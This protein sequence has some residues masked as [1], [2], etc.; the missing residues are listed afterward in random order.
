[1]NRCFLLIVLLVGMLFATSCQE[2]SCESQIGSLTTFTLKLPDQI[3]TK[4]FGDGNSTNETINKLYVQVYSEY[5]DKLIYEPL[6]P[7]SVSSGS[8]S[9][10]VNLIQ[11]QK[12]DIIFWAQK[13]DAYNTSDLRLIPMDKKYHNIE[14]GAAFF[15]YLND[16]IPTGA[17][18][19][20]E[21][22]RPFAQ[23]NLGT[24]PASLKTDVQEDSIKLTK[25]YIKVAN[26]AS[27]FNT[28]L[29]CGEG[30]QVVEF[31]LANVPTEKLYVD[32][33]MYYY[34]S[35]DYLPIAGDKQALVT[36]NASITLD[37]DDNK[38]VSHE[39]VNVPVKENYRT[40][41]IGNLISST[42]DFKVSIDEDFAK[43]N[44]GNLFPDNNINVWDG[45]TLS[46][47]Y[48]EGL[49][50]TFVINDASELA[51]L[52]AVLNDEITTQTPIESI[53]GCTLLVRNNL[54]FGGYAITP[55]RNAY[56]IVFDGGGY[57]ISDLSYSKGVDYST[58]F[59]LASGTFKDIN[60]INIKAN[61]PENN[62]ASALIGYF[63]AGS[64]S[65]VSVRNLE[66]KGYQKLAGI[67]ANLS[68]DASNNKEILVKDCVVENIKI[69]AGIRGEVYQAGGL[70]GYINSSSNAIL[71]F[72]N[73][74]VN[75]S[76]EINDTPIL[77]YPSCYNF[78]SNGF[79]G[80]ISSNE[81]DSKNP[82]IYI[83]DC[84]VVG[85]SA[86]PAL[87]LSPSGCSF[88]GDCV[89]EANP[90]A[91][92]KP[93]K[94]YIDG[95]KY[96]IK[97][98]DQD[99]AASGTIDGYDYVDL[100]LPSGL[101]W[102]TCNVGASS[103]EGYGDYYAWGELETK[104]EYS[105]INSSTHGKSMND[106]SGNI[107]FDVVQSKWGI[108]WRMPKNTELLELIS[109]CI[110]E[111]T[112]V[113]DI[114]GWKVTGSNG[115]SIFLPAAGYKG[116]PFYCGEQGFYWSSTPYNDIEHDGWFSY[117]LWFNHDGKAVGDCMRRDGLTIRPVSDED[118]LDYEENQDYVASGTIDGYDYV[119]LGL[120]S[121]LKWA[122]CNVGAS[123]IYEIGD[124]YAWGELEPGLDYSPK[125][126]NDISGNP[127]YDVATVKWSSNWRMPTESE[128]KELLLCCSYEWVNVGSCYGYKVIG[129][130]G[131]S[132]FFP[133]SPKYGEF[134]YWGSTSISYSGVGVDG[135]VGIGALT[136]LF[137]NFYSP[138]FK[139]SVR[140][141][142]GNK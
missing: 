61:N 17:S 4:A 114:N 25:S 62:R 26:V 97:I 1:M 24:S 107:N 124:L 56:N 46:Q 87:S 126:L 89:T 105:E 65:G 78:Y 69:G 88:F 141:V 34:I 135:A 74:E 27:F 16:F 19:L 14:D 113:K 67:I 71:R 55:I 96:E 137:M 12:Y 38:K 122:T 73:C 45:K 49:S 103:I 7:I 83:D 43:D 128:I 59:E 28:I 47:P 85:V 53:N 79:I 9:F 91:S 118:N 101:K 112:A 48:Y 68:P 18:Q 35:M 129:P 41:I 30:E 95:I 64:V 86:T 29:G 70:V 111:W 31:S 15:A 92:R 21:L 77:D 33:Q 115:K 60:L 139:H 138:Q 142:S 127:K 8:A 132:V 130:N 44:E 11:D 93:S 40:N 54:N 80:S 13:N 20:V 36:V 32:G 98:A 125:N 133:E 99:Y 119:D 100:G 42:T 23:L 72:V 39:F 22:K 94:I 110:W 2:S 52:S 81:D 84:K 104:S 120:P 51:W 75:G 50:K 109:E 6:E 102:A 63:S 57:T 3:Q 140:P 131:N 82:I 136:T 108:N 116:N 123:L 121:G 10:S 58:L 90:V 106:I 5:G 117:A 66:L 37:N 134:Y 76:V